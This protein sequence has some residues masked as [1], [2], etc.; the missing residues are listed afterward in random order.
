TRVHRDSVAT[1]GDADPGGRPWVGQVAATRVAQ[2]GDLVEVDAERGHRTP[3][4]GGTAILVVR[5]PRRFHAGTAP[6]GRGD[7][8]TATFGTWFPDD[9]L[10]VSAVGDARQL[11]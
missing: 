3:G 9:R 7:G 11:R 6:A 8:S 5:R 2:D 4:R 10:P 1:G